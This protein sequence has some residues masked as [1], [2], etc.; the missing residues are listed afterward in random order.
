MILFQVNL[1]DVGVDQWMYS[2]TYMNKTEEF[3]LD[4][5]FDEMSV[6]ER[7]HAILG[8]VS[9]VFSQESENWLDTRPGHTP[10]GEILNEM[11]DQF[12]EMEDSDLDDLEDGN[13]QA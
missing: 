10:E 12:R 11:Y 5:P 2:C 6:R 7:Q 1:E 9:R 3:T 13:T 4:L 8:M